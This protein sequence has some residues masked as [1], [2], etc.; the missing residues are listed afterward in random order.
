MDPELLKR[1][2]A[3]GAKLET[4]GA[5]LW[6]SAV[7]HT[8]ATA[9]GSMLVAA[10]TIAALAIYARWILRDEDRKDELANGHPGY[11]IPLALLAMAAF[12][13]TIIACCYVADLI[14]PEGATLKA[15]IGGKK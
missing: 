8:Q 15:L 10:V 6:R 5:A 14:A 7:A 3:I 11:G 2:D 9:I 4:T 1:L 12:A 13:A